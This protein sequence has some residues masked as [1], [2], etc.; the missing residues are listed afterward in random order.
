MIFTCH[1]LFVIKMYLFPLFKNVVVFE[2]AVEYKGSREIVTVIFESVNK[3]RFIL[4]EHACAIIVMFISL[5]FIWKNNDVHV[6]I[7]FSIF[8]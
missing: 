6:F 7:I 5:I 3:Y 8:F 4:T 2:F 1:L